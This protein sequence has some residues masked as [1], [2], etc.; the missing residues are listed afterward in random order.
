MELTSRDN[1]VRDGQ[2]MT[3]M[4][5][6]GPMGQGDAGRLEHGQNVQ[7]CYPFL[8]LCCS[9]PSEGAGPTSGA[10]WKLPRSR[11][12]A[13]GHAPAPADYYRRPSPAAVQA[14]IGLRHPVMGL[15]RAVPPYVCPAAG[16][17]E[18]KDG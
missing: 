17:Q 5:R 2:R 11:S 13:V 12:R 4:G 15:A 14:E 18:G 9:V 7:L 6:P 10:A 1:C 8:R 16:L 3:W